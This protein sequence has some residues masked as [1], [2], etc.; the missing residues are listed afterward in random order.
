MNIAAGGLNRDGRFWSA[1]RFAQVQTAKR[2]RRRRAAHLPSEAVAEP[3]WDILL[4][5][6]AFE[7]VGRAGSQTEI[8]ERIQV[9]STT[10]IRWMKVLEAADLIARTI[11][12]A[13]PLS[14][15]VGMTP[16]GLAAMEAY[17]SG[18]D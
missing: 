11:D 4:E 7:L 6:Y 9:P 13:D 15:K 8:A 17:F 3:A 2:E 10:S 18:A 14:V 5:L 12:P 1:I 16:K